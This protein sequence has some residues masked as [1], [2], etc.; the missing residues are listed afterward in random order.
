MMT[1]LDTT[2]KNMKKKA[3]SLS[4]VSHYYEMGVEMLKGIRGRDDIPKVSKV[5]EEMKSKYGEVLSTEDWDKVE[6]QLLDY[7]V[8]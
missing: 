5:V 6:S 2:V 7:A 8:M 4:M 3:D 1:L